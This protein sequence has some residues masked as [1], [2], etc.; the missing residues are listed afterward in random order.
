MNDVGFLVLGSRPWNTL[1]YTI[2]LMRSLT[3]R[4]LISR[5]LFGAPK[6]RV[7][8][9]THR[10]FSEFRPSPAEKRLIWSGRATHALLEPSRARIAPRLIHE[11][12]IG[13]EAITKLVSSERA[14]NYIGGQSRPAVRYENRRASAAGPVSRSIAW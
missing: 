12:S 6:R 13:F 14:E 10:V 9:K 5:M 7:Y 8:D 2:K 11:P 4:F 3:S 1:R